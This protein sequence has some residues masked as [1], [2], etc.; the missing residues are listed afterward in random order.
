MESH[1][2]A[3][4]RERALDDVLALSPFERMALALALG[5]DDVARYMA[6]HDLDH[7][8]AVSDLRRAR[9]AGRRPSVA[10]ESRR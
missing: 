2:A 1:A 4:L 8:P 6:A 10:N 3:F 5:D 7:D 9:A